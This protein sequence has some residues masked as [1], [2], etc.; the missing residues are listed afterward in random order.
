MINRTV[1]N[2]KALSVYG[3]KVGPWGLVFHHRSIAWIDKN[4]NLDA[5]PFRL[6]GTIFPHDNAVSVE[7]CKQFSEEMTVY[8]LAIMFQIDGSPYLHFPSFL[9]NQVGLRRNRENLECPEYKDQLRILP[10]ILPD[11]YQGYDGIEPEESGKDDGIMTE[12][13]ERKGRKEKKETIFSGKSK[14]HTQLIKDL[15]KGG[16]LNELHAIA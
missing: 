12:E 5:N 2:D 9:K 11:K 16:K 4:G 15:I 3:E 10:Q 7:D 14:D 8:G 1:G 6:K 13:I